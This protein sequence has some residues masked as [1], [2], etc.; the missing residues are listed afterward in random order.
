MSPP[1]T[2]NQLGVYPVTLTEGSDRSANFTGTEL[3]MLETT[4]RMIGSRA[5]SSPWLSVSGGLRR[6]GQLSAEPLQLVTSAGQRD[7]KKVVGP[8][9]ASEFATPALMP[10]T[11][12]DITVTTKTPTAMPR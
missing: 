1:A 7:T 5:M 10:C 4:L 12:A 9:A 2:S 11:A 3:P 8:A 6:H